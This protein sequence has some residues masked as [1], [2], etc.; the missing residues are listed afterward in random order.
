MNRF[1]REKV[2][3]IC[4]RVEGATLLYWNWIR[5]DIEEDPNLRGE[6]KREAIRRERRRFDSIIATAIYNV[7]EEVKVILSRPEQDQ[8]VPE[9]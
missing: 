8:A 3:E 1:T 2:Q 9:S 6:A 7:L 4:R 5:S